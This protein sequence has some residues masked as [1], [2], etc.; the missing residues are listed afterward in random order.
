MII[1]RGFEI[2]V[3]PA[4]LYEW[5]DENGITHNGKVDFAG[6]F[7]TDAEAMDDIDRYKRK[8]RESSE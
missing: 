5:Q 2:T 4:G 6:G 1:Y 7:T 8:Q 3:T